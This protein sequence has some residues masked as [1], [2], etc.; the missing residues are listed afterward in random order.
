MNYFFTMLVSL[1]IFGAFTFFLGC[2]YAECNEPDDDNKCNC[3]DPNECEKW[4]NAKELFTQATS[5][6]ITEECK[7][8]N[9]LTRLLEASST[10]ETTIEV[11]ASC[12]EPLTK[13]KTDCR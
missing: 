10:C 11:C 8:Q 1:A 5:Y 9:R 7:H 12:N 2:L 13:P 6:K 3:T 4:C